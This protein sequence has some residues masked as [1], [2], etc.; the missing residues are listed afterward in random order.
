V[1]NYVI[2]NTASEADLGEMLTY[3]PEVTMS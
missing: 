1:L 3:V 2:D